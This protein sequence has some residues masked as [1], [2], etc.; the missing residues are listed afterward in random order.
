M[1]NQ[2]FT[3]QSGRITGAKTSPKKPVQT[4]TAPTD[5]NRV[6]KP[7]AKTT[8]E[9]RGIENKTLTPQP[10]KTSV[11]ANAKAPVSNEVAKPNIINPSLVMVQRASGTSVQQAVQA[12]AAR[13]MVKTRERTDTQNGSL[14]E[15]AKGGGATSSR[16]EHQ[17]PHV[18]SSS[19]RKI[20][21]NRSNSR[22]ST[23]PKTA[24]GKRHSR[25]NALKHGILSNAL[26]IREGP[27]AEDQAAFDKSLLS[28]RHAHKPGNDREEQ[29]VEEIAICDW[30]L[31]RCL[32]CEAGLISRNVVIHQFGPAPEVV[33]M[34]TLLGQ[35]AE[36][37]RE[38]QLRG[39]TDHLSLPLGNP[40]DRLLRYQ[41]AI[42]RLKA[43]KIVELERLQ[44]RRKGEHVPAP[45]KVHLSTDE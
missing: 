39:L 14:R 36:N 8:V 2:R 16:R 38:Q 42:Q 28:L 1:Q 10:L 25:R 17:K 15:A 19:P 32:R 31:A 9:R 30:R 33:H 44:L 18:T 26:L 13:S 23:G 40:L 4:S 22:K 7:V 11:Q 43:S 12:S 41:T 5:L 29:V 20:A 6:P 27:G 3:A 45:V 21:A 34:R 24:R 35:D 37:K